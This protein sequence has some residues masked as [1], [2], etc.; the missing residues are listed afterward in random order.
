VQDHDEHLSTAERLRREIAS[1]RNHPALAV[2]GLSGVLALLDAYL[3][4][5]EDRITTLE[6]IADE[7]EEAIT[8]RAR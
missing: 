7:H 8:A 2:S 3:A 1:R 4:E 6:V 5:T